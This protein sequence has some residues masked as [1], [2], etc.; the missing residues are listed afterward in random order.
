MNGFAVISKANEEDVKNKFPVL[1]KVR[2]MDSLMLPYTER[3][4]NFNSFVG[5][6][7]N[8]TKGFERAKVKRA[9]K[10]GIRHYGHVVSKEFNINYNAFFHHSCLVRAL[11]FYTVR[12]GCDLRLSEVVIADAATVEGRN[13]FRLLMPIARRIL[14]VTENKNSLS[15]EV[16]YAM[17]RFG[18]SAAVI[19]DPVK[20]SE[21]ADVLVLSSENPNH[22]YLTSLQRPMLYFKSLDKPS[23]RMWFDDVGI[24][25]VEGEEL[26]SLYAQG[27]LNVIKKEA[28]WRLAEDEGFVIKSLMRENKK[29]IER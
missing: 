11:D 23:G 1:S 22:R 9:Y 5:A 8:I 27:Y 7:V 24:S 28:L 29:I 6:K 2:G 21:K 15:E 18:I 20:A 12:M 3:E 17:N 13:A 14:L 10:I 4:F 19:E 16:E 26:E 25:Y